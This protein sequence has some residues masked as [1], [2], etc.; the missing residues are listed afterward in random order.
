[1]AK[2][3]KETAKKHPIRFA[4]TLLAYLAMLVLICIYF[5]GNGAFI[6]EGF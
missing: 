3:L 2:H 1:M 4:L 6:Y 5:Q